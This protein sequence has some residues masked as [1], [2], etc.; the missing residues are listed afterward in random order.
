[1]LIRK[2]QQPSSFPKNNIKDAYT[3]S[4]TD[5]YSCNFVNDLGITENGIPVVH[6]GT[7]E[8]TS[9]IGKNGDIYILVE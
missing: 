7:T 6:T 9:D 8:P 5:V 1:M 3:D 4:E 2:I